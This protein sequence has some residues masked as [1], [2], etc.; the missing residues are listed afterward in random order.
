MHFSRQVGLCTH[1]KS[2]KRQKFSTP[3]LSVWKVRNRATHFESRLTNVKK[4]KKKKKWGGKE[5]PARSVVA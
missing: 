3:V 1:G 4:K 5:I 2:V